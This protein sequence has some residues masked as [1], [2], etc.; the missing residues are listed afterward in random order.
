M[1]TQVAKDLGVNRDGASISMVFADDGNDEPNSIVAATINVKKVGK[2]GTAEIETVFD[3]KKMKPLHTR[4]YEA[5]EKVSDSCEGLY[6]KHFRPPDEITE[7]D[8]PEDIPEI[9][10]DNR[11]RQ[12]NRVGIVILPIVIL[13]GGLRSASTRTDLGAWS[14]DM[15]STLAAQVGALG[16]AAR[17][18][19]GGFLNIGAWCGE[20]FGILA[21]WVGALGGAARSFF[22]GFL[23]ALF[24]VKEGLFLEGQPPPPPPRVAFG[25]VGTYILIALLLGALIF[26]CC[27]GLIGGRD[28]E[29]EER[30]HPAPPLAA[31]PTPKKRRPSPAPPSRGPSPAPDRRGDD[32]WQ[33]G[34]RNGKKFDAMWTPPR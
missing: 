21:A 15:I 7:D 18:F 17:S 9:Q 25:G 2:D 8:D 32:G 14:G 26:G 11:Y 23:R 13:V 27:L 19:F 30:R 12:R 34:L 22:G 6:Q 24:A 29:E 16:G 10:A 4:M 3:R 5:V 28:D 20:I 31:A 1:T 33:M